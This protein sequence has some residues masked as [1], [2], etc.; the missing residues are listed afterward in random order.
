MDEA[1]RGVFGCARQ[2]AAEACPVQPER[3]VRRKR[4]RFDFD[5]SRPGVRSF[6]T[7]AAAL[8]LRDA[9]QEGERQL[10]AAFRLAISIGLGGGFEPPTLVHRG[11]RILTVKT[12]PAIEQVMRHKIVVRAWNHLDIR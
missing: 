8:K 3:P 9:E 2:H 6:D 1:C 7:L 11:V 10:T 5:R 12:M 4:E